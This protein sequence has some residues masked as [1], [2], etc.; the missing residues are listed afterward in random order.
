MKSLKNILLKPLKQEPPENLFQM[1]N[2][3]SP[4][5][6]K[7]V[8]DILM[9]YRE[10]LMTEP[11]TY[12]VPAVWGAGGDAPLD[13]TQQEIHELISPVVDEVFNSLELQNLRQQQRFAIFFLIRGLFISKI[14][15]STEVFKN[16]LNEEMNVNHEMTNL[17]DNIDP[18]GTA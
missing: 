1:T 17:L 18:S 2:F 11:I 10:K 9:K 3:I 7:T 16:R 14:V 15:H 4:V 5:V 13:S 6:D 8:M 12:I